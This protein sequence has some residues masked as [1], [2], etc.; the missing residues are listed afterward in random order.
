MGLLPL[1]T[2]V[3]QNG[4][5]NV[6]AM[7][8]VAQL[9]A[10]NL[11]FTQVSPESCQFYGDTLFTWITGVATGSRVNG[12]KRYTS[13]Y[14]SEFGNLMS[15]GMY[16]GLTPIFV[17]VIAAHVLVDRA[18]SMQGIVYKLLCRPRRIGDQ[19]AVR[20]LPKQNSLISFDK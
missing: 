3:Y 14:V 10:N 13:P 2:V 19:S 8:M 11:A 9:Q 5:A 7:N 4:G 1:V 17:R 16:L 6:I 18:H 20:L 12:Y 15:H